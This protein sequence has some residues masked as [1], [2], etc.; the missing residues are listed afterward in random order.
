MLLVEFRLSLDE[1]GKID[2]SPNLLPTHIGVYF[3]GTCG[4]L[5]KKEGTYSFDPS[6]ILSGSHGSLVLTSSS[7][8]LGST[9]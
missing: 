4:S 3:V 2:F 8:V 9:E 7:S 6:S 1:G 5:I